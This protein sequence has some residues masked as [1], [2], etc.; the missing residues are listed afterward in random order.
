MADHEI[1]NDQKHLS[2]LHSKN[3]VGRQQVRLLWIV[4]NFAFFFSRDQLTN[5]IYIQQQQHLQLLTI[6]VRRPGLYT[7]NTE[8]GLAP[9]L[10][11][12]KIETFTLVH[13][14]THTKQAFHLLRAAPEHQLRQRCNSSIFAPSRHVRASFLVWRSTGPPSTRAG[15]E[16]RARTQNVMIGRLT[17]I[18]VV[19]AQLSRGDTGRE[20]LRAR[21]RWEKYGAKAGPSGTKQRRRGE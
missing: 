20:L 1:S 10:L 3:C 21:F 6:Q 4:R 17:A 18:I 14:H 12:S 15:P 19:M 11:G 8:H 9:S 16:K 7:N 5:Q 13:A 2:Y